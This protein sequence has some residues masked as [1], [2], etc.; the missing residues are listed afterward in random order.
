MMTLFSLTAMTSLLAGF[1]IRVE[2]EAPGPL[3]AAGVG[4]IEGL[5]T[6]TERF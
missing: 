4:K 1:P 5:A 3:G 6:T 2:S